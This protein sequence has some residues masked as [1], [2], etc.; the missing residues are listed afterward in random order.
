MPQRFTFTPE[1]SDGTT[2]IPLTKAVGVWSIDDVGQV[3]YE[4]HVRWTSLPPGLNGNLRLSIP[5]PSNTVGEAGWSRSGW[6][7]LPPVPGWEVT[8][9][10][11]GG[12][13]V[14]RFFW[15]G[16]FSSAGVPIPASMISAA[17]GI[18]GTVSYF[19]EPLPK[20]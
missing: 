10:I 2:T 12:E 20:S 6:R 16:S 17:G 18:G 8:A 15:T 9:L 13:D 11:V 19:S 4:F 7:G 5:R 1:L 3:T 14:L